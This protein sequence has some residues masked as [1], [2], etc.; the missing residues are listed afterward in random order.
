MTPLWGTVPKKNN[1]YYTAVNKA[2][3]ATLDLATRRTATP[4][5]R[6][7]ARSSPS[8]D[9]PDVVIIPG[10]NM[11]GQIRNAIIAKFADLG[12]YLAGDTVKKYPNLANI[13]TDA[14]QH[15]VFGGKLPRSADAARRSSTSRSSTART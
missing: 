11:Q 10:W 14:W 6:R 3:G 15:S 2:V 9:I 8:S 5:T 7:S 13:P 4:T 1:P 12:P